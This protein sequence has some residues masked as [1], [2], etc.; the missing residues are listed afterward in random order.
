MEETV[1]AD[2]DACTRARNWGSE[3]LD[4]F[5]L[6]LEEGVI[7]NSAA[8]TSIRCRIAEGFQAC[9]STTKETAHLSCLTSPHQ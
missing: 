8:A 5:G 1:V 6:K 3:G 9:Y 7:M 2:L 4:S